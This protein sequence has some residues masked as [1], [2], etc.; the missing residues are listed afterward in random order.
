ME[1]S[2]GTPFLTIR[3][4]QSISSAA[5]C[6]TFF[7]SHP[8]SAHVPP[9]G[10]SSTIATFQPALL[11]FAA[12]IEPAEPVPITIRSYFFIIINLLAELT[13]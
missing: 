7:G 11:H 3:L 1:T 10:L 9:N 6:R 12:V 4:F 13:L 8:R 2:D 5:P